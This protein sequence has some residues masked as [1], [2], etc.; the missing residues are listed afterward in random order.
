MAEGAAA[1]DSCLLIL[2]MIELNDGQF[3]LKTASGEA[4]RERYAFGEG[5][6]PVGQKH[7]HL[8]Y[9]SNK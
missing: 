5:L 3:Q 6:K 9:L 7:F 2:F 1:E 4:A 8:N